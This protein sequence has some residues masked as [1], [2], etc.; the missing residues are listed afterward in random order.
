MFWGV[1]SAEAQ[2][3]L[4]GAFPDHSDA[5]QSVAG[6]SVPVGPAGPTGRAAGI[7]AGPTGSGPR[8]VGWRVGPDGLLDEGKTGERIRSVS[9]MLTIL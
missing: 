1:L 8:R 6:V 5:P 2:P 4:D 3:P 7:P 9:S